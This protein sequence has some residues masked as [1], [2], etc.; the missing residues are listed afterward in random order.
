MAYK[1]WLGYKKLLGKWVRLAK[2]R[3]Y[4]L[5]FGDLHGEWGREGFPP[6][7]A[8]HP[9]QLSHGRIHLALQFGLIAQDLIQHLPLGQNGWRLFGFLFGGF[10]FLAALHPAMNEG[11][12]PIQESQRLH[13][14]RFTES[15]SRQLQPEILQCYHQTV[16]LPA[17]LALQLLHRRFRQ[18][19]VVVGMMFL[20]LK[21][22][23]VMRRAVGAECATPF[24]RCWR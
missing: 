13:P 23:A 16:R 15:S 8:L 6:A 22:Q 19:M 3:F 24:T 17:K 14:R 2:K 7:H 18:G 20:G 10:I 21:P 12:L 5:P 9:F 4:L 1:K 11:Q